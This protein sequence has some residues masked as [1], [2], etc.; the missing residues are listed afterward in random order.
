MEFYTLIYL[1]NVV[2]PVEIS[3][4]TPNATFLR[5]VMRYARKGDVRRSSGEDSLSTASE[6]CTAMKRKKTGSVRRDVDREQRTDHHSM[7]N[8]ISLHFAIW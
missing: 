6:S 5:I 3:M 1:Q 2:I 7:V 4:V 8:M